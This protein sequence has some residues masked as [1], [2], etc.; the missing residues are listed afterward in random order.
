MLKYCNKQLDK[1]HGK[2]AN[3]VNMSFITY[4]INGIA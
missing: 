2:H 4:L 1:M 3:G